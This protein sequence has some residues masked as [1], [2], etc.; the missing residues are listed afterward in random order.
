MVETNKR[1]RIRTDQLITLIGVFVPL[2]GTVIAMGLVWQRQA[3]GRDVVILLSMYVA[4]GIGITV[5]FHRMLTHH[6]FQAHHAVRFVLLA[7]GCMAGHTDPIRWTAIHLQHHAHSDLDDDP[8]TPLQ[9]LFH[10]HLGWIYDGID[11]HPEVYARWL[12]KDRMALFF[13]QTFVGWLALGYIVPFLLGGWTGL[14]W[15]GLVRMFLSH[16]ITWSVNSVCHMFG[17]RPFATHD[18]STNNWWIGLLALGEGW[19]NNH[20]AFPRSAIHGLRWW[21]IDL[22]A[23]VI[24]ILERLG[25]V[26]HVQRVSSPAQAARLA[27]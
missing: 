6:S 16:H 11:P 18:Q 3:T 13:Q 8:H 9:G 14:L 24:V 19:H 1:I 17:K 25:L 21:Q 7:L 22:S 2:I 20:H 5:G 12:L 23:C 27:K 26:W 4:T 10:A 15:G